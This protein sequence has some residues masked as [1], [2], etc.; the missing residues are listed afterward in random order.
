MSLEEEESVL[1]PSLFLSFSLSSLSLSVSL[2]LSACTE[3]DDHVRTQGEDT[4]C[5][6]GRDL[7]LETNPADT[8]ISDVQP[9]NW[10]TINVS[11]MSQP[12]WASLIR[13]P[14]PSH[15]RV[16]NPLTLTLSS[17]FSSPSSRTASQ[18]PG[19][20]L[21]SF[22]GNGCQERLRELLRILQLYGI[23]PGT[24]LSRSDTD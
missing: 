22:L 16:Y 20:T 14:E 23:L 13:Q 7:S 6:P 8:L 24:L 17:R 21:P 15:A 12:I 10:E 9:P 1:P 5:K 2:Y 18:Q 19:N 4:I 11:W 3:R